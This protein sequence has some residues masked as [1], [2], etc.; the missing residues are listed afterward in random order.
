LAP[1]QGGNSG[2]FLTTDGTNAS[3]ARA[4]VSIAQVTTATTATTLTYIP[5]LLQITP[6]SYGVTVTL[7]D[8]T[9]C[10]VGGPLH[11]IDN[12]GAFPVRIVNTSGTLLGFVFAGVVS[13]ISLDN[14]STAAGVWAISSNELV[15]ASAQ[16][17]SNVTITNC[18]DLG[19]SRELL[20]GTN[21]ST[22]AVGV[23]Y[24]KSTNTFGAVTTIRAVA[25]SGVR[26]ILSAADQAL[27][28]SCNSTTGFEAVT[29][30]ISGTTITV[31]TAA[32]ATLSGNFVGFNTET[33]LI[34]VSTSF[35]TSY[36]V[37]GTICQIRALTVSGTTV[38]IGAASIP[39]GTMG[40]GSLGAF[41]FASGSVVVAI[42]ATAATALYFQPYTVSG[43]TLTIGTGASV[44]GANCVIQY[45]FVTGSG[46]FW[47]FGS[48]AAAS[49]SVIHLATLSGTTVTVNSVAHGGGAT[50]VTSYAVISTTKVA[51]SLGATTNNFNIA[52]D[53]SGTP[54]V[55][56]VISLAFPSI[57]YSN[58]NWSYAFGNSGGSTG[59]YKIDCSGASPTTSTSKIYST[60]T[61]APGD[62]GNPFMQLPGLPTAAAVYSSSF[63]QN[64]TDPSAGA[65]YTFMLYGFRIISDQISDPITPWQTGLNSSFGSLYRGLTT[66]EAYALSGN[67]LTK[68]ECVA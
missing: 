15:G 56:T 13:Y 33:G 6:A 9:T 59:V 12:R 2:K 8:A 41:I 48:T 25:L 68:L 26:A 67:R 31:N 23:V 42:S 14:N 44:A 57:F 10:P 11:C 5:T 45:A 37:T 64:L 58:G 4:G 61:A 55:G 20:V 52:V 28:V 1:N 18:I 63:Y 43:S 24:D 7:P 35:V 38:T 66:R 30:S 51:F 54:T 62:S 17:S 29:I 3:W 46:R 40:A 36:T 49:T 19:G 39:T 50:L 27:V 53:G 34:A 22:Y 47:C 21:L 65:R 60:G 16:L 32:T